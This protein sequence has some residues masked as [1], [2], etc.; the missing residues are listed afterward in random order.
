MDTRCSPPRKYVLAL[1]RCW[2]PAS[3]KRAGY[4]KIRL[5]QTDG[6]ISGE[7]VYTRGDC[8]G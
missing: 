8:G 1:W 7:Y 3:E 5:S 2:L 6:W 4:F